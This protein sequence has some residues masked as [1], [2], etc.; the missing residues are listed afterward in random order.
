MPY[1]IEEVPRF[2]RELQVAVG[3]GDHPHIG[4]NLSR[5]S[6]ALKFTLLNNPLKRNLSF[7]GEFSNFV[8]EDTAVLCQLKASQT[9]Q[10]CPR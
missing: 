5:F 1:K 9:T 10:S 7:R 3:G 6:D 2:D 8:E 4:A